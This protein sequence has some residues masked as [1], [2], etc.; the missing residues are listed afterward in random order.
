MGV[1]IGDGVEVASRVAV[2]VGVGAGTVVGDGGV[3]VM[4]EEGVF[5]VSGGIPSC[6]PQDGAK[7]AKE[8]TNNAATIR[9]AGKARTLIP[10]LQ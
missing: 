2:G 1:G 7:T 8:N 5:V 3:A 4:R 9:L 10:S 6:S